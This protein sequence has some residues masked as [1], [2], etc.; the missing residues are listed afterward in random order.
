MCHAI[1]IAQNPATLNTEKRRL[2]EIAGSVERLY[3]IIRYYKWS[4][5]VCTWRY[6]EVMLAQEQQKARHLASIGTSSS[7]TAA[8]KEPSEHENEFYGLRPAEARS[9]AY[10]IRT[11]HKDFDPLSG[12]AS[13]LMQAAL[14]SVD[15]PSSV[16]ETLTNLEMLSSVDK[17]PL[18]PNGQVFQKTHVKHARTHQDVPASAPRTN[19]A[20][21]STSAN[22]ATRS[23]MLK[24]G[25]AGAPSLSIRP[26]MVA[27]RKRVSNN[28]LFDSHFL[29]ST[30][31]TRSTLY[32]QEVTRGETVIQNVKPLTKLE[33]ELEFT[34][35]NKAKWTSKVDRHM[36]LAKK[37][38]VPSGWK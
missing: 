12:S 5:T 4:N 38:A 22:G 30:S 11:L 35:A 37:A 19:T 8:G 13:A 28:I 16:S 7:P 1:L 25:T 29:F 6:P 23:G 32:V 3:D 34:R 24:S 21:T 27:P 2:L 17:N 10:I 9:S 33:K 31:K 26:T 20:R 14:G 36:D 15:L 18:L